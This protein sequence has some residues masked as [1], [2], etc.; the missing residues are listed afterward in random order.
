[1]GGKIGHI[2]ARLSQELR[3]R[4]T[5]INNAY[6]TSDAGLLEDALSALAD[7][8]EGRGGYKRPIKIVFDAETAELLRF[9]VAEGAEGATRKP[10]DDP[11]HNLPKVVV[12][13][14]LT[15]LGTHPPSPPAKPPGLHE[16]PHA[17]EGKRARKS[18]RKPGQG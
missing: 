5:A 13:E 10:P 18:H 4:I 9:A 17:G 2:S 7:Y 6:G 8:V 14:A 16:S 1:M 12:D 11:S 3:T 15:H